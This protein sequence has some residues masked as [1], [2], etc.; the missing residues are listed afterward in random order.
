MDFSAILAYKSLFFANRAGNTAK[1][2]K[3]GKTCT[4]VANGARCAIT[5]SQAIVPLF[6]V[7]KCLSL[8]AETPTVKNVAQKVATSNLEKIATAMTSSTTQ[9]ALKSMAGIMGFLAK[10]G[11]VGNVTYAVAKCADADEQNKNKILMQAAGNCGGM[12]LCEYL[13]SKAIKE[14]SPNTVLNQVDNIS[15]SLPEK[16]KLFKSVKPTSIL[17][18][19]GF[20]AASLFGCWAGEKLGDG[21]YE[22]TTPLSVKNLAPA[23][24]CSADSDKINIVA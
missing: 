21:L 9:S 7:S 15:K 2:A 13:Y 12:Y 6:A 19:V 20:V 1:Q 5:A 23:T 17:T 10:L 18:G 24:V 16:L 11:I 14:I 8:T 4:S 22:T 3:E